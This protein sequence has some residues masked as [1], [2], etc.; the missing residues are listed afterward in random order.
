VLELKVWRDRKRDPLERGLEQLEGYLERVG[1]KRGVLVIF[2][3][4]GS[5]K[6][7][8]ERVERSEVRTKKGHKVTLL[9]A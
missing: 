8:E 4:R 3:R 1:V 7:V 5:A 9:R 6:A 2:D